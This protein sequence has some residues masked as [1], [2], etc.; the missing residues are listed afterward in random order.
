MSGVIDA[1]MAGN[2]ACKLHKLKFTLLA[3]LVQGPRRAVSDETG[4]L[5]E[6]TKSAQLKI[7]LS[8]QTVAEH[9]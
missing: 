4:V 1:A 7:F 6:L 3:N 8:A 2:Q 9:A 5:F